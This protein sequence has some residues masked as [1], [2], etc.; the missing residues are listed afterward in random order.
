MV[1]SS[2]STGKDPDVSLSP[3]KHSPFRFVASTRAELQNISFSASVILQLFAF[4]NTDGDGIP[5]FLADRP[6]DW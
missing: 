3:L 4:H 6:Q 1:F 5:I 2:W